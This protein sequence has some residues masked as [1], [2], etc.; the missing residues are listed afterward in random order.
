MKKINKSRNWYVYA[1]S[2]TAATEV[3][4]HVLL[5]D[6]EEG[7]LTRVGD[8]SGVENPSYLALDHERSRLF[9]VSETEEGSVVSYAIDGKTRQLQEMNRQSTNGASP[10]YVSLDPTGSWLFAVNYMGGS[11]CSFPIKADGTVG[12]LADS[13]HHTGSSVRSDR[14]EAA[15]P[16]SVVT[17]PESPYRLVADLGTDRV[18]VYRLNLTDGKWVRTGEI[19]TDPGA[20]PRHIAFHPNAPF[21]YVAN[22]LNSTITVY[23]CDRNAGSLSP[24]QTASALPSKF[25]GDNT[26][27]DI[28]VSPSG[29]YLYASN[30]GHDSIASFRLLEDGTLAP[31]GHTSSMGK[32]P[33][34]FAIVPDG[35]HLL[36]ANQDS[37][38]IVV[39]AIG[40]NGVPT[41]TGEVYEMPRPVCLQLLRDDRR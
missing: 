7:S 41:P 23:T 13:V 29:R 25:T 19:A 4:I 28:H 1:G 11:V 20:G 36:V 3:G 8:L 5:F 34:N 26:C 38:T 6:G 10:C 12:P 9:A 22:E 16:H 14:Q 37:D 2:Y 15:H 30:R 35:K 18:Y 31:I 24:I 32:T 21:A 27:A 17:M 39:M 40:E 33:R